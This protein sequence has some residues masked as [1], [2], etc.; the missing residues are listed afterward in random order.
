MLVKKENQRESSKGLK[1]KMA[2]F[3]N[4][5]LTELFSYEVCKIKVKQIIPAFYIIKIQQDIYQQ[6]NESLLPPSYLPLG[7]IN[8]FVG[9]INTLS[10]LNEAYF[11]N[12]CKIIILSSCAGM[13]K[14]TIA[15]EFGLH[16]KA[17][18]SHYYVYWMKSDKKNIEIEFKSFGNSLEIQDEYLRDREI[19]MRQI[20]SRLNKL[21]KEKILF[22]FDNCDDYQS[23]ECYLNNLPS[24]V[25]ILI[26]T[27]DSMLFNDIGER[28][29]Q[30]DHLIVEPFD[31]NECKDFIRK[32]LGNR[33]K[34]D[35]DLS[36]LVELIE[37]ERKKI[38]PYLL[39]NIIAFIKLKIGLTRDLGEFLARAHNDTRN[40]MFNDDK[41]LN[42]II[43]T[44]RNAW[45]ILIYSSYLDPDFISI[46]IFT[47]LL[48]ID[49]EQVDDSIQF[50]TRLSLVKLEELE[51]DN[52]QLTFRMHR[53]LQEEIHQYLQATN[54]Q[55]MNE[56][57]SEYVSVL[58]R[59]LSKNKEFQK[60]EGLFK[61]T[62][63][64][65]IKSLVD[66]VFKSS[67]ITDE[68]KAEL[69]FNFG[70]Y[71]F[72]LEKYSESLKHYEI[73]L[74]FYENDRNKYLEI[75]NILNN[76]GETYDKI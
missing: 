57:I 55:E 34:N 67:F 39:N 44:N 9:R 61:N 8:N 52:R 11:E 3:E 46:E 59:I 31:E 1:R 23:I 68:I 38:R 22:I 2:S 12:E 53:T 58:R 69:R 51:D 7:K 14:S 25:L 60:D 21:N 41:L 13:G 36:R 17:K 49:E 18:K 37:Y 47:Q 6:I 72:N 43:I 63:Y 45:T 73:C 54:E 28:N 56:I 4:S 66:N 27:R 33:L 71:N 30:I 19:L 65:N 35:Q 50:L 48:N 70:N 5:N 64:Y 10:R 76:M 42:E 24:N 26:T 40:S 16:F 75:A 62:Y 29:D 32:N 74:S 20:N 15:N